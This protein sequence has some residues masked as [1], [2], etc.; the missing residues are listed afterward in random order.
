MYNLHLKITKTD[1]DMRLK[2]V[3]VNIYAWVDV[4]CIKLNYQLEKKYPFLKK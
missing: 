2:Y 3:A 1:Y 4:Q